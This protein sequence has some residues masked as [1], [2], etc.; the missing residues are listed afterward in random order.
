MV[1]KHDKL[2]LKKQLQYEVSY[3]YRRNNSR[4]KSA[5]VEMLRD[6]KKT[7]ERAVFFGGTLRSLLISRLFKQRHGRPRDIDIVVSGNSVDEV[8]RLFGDRISRTTRFGGLQLCHENWLF[9]VWPLENTWAFKADHVKHPN[10][11][12]LPMTTFF[13][14]E[15]IA[16]DVWNEPGYQRQIYSA[17]DQFFDGILTRTIEINRE[18]NP[19]PEL[20]VVRALVMAAE[21][22]FRLGPKLVS[23]VVKHGETLTPSDIEQVQI[24]H[25]GHQRFHSHL[26]KDWISF[27]ATEKSSDTEGTHRLPLAQQQRFWSYDR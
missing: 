13:N 15:A 20:C 25:Y 17:D 26:M 10:F 22:E 7:T 14:L 21:L 27:L 16:M 12:D 18:E 5:V 11:S 6:L 1:S 4:W 8:K 19:F 9:D 3:L 2:H 23:Y 24:S